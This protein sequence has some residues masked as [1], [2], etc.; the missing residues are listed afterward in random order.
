MLTYLKIMYNIIFYKSAV[1]TNEEPFLLIEVL[2]GDAGI[3]VRG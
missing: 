1:L 2:K 3:L